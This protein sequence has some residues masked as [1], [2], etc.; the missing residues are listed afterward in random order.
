MSV[1]LFRGEFELSD[2]LGGAVIYAGSDRTRSEYKGGNSPGM[3]TYRA[4]YQCHGLRRSAR[5]ISDCLSYEIHVRSSMLSKLL[6]V[7]MIE[8]KGAFVSGKHFQVRSSK[9][10]MVKNDIGKV[11]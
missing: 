3:G 6:P 1:C 8:S 7:Q 4:E 5:F 10:Y 2:K 11:I 9:S